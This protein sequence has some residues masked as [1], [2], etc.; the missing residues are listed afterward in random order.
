MLLFALLMVIPPWQHFSH[1]FLIFHDNLFVLPLENAF[2]KRFVRGGAIC[3]HSGILVHILTYLL[4]LR[5]VLQVVKGFHP[6][7]TNFFG[8]TVFLHFSFLTGDF[9]TFSHDQSSYF[10]LTATPPFNGQDFSDEGISI[11]KKPSSSS[12]S[13]SDDT[14]NHA[15]PSHHEVYAPFPKPAGNTYVQIAAGSLW[16][17]RNV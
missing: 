14:K 10:L 6:D 13:H 11:E 9:R 15:F 3:G 4:L 1:H 5:G 12:L 2:L 8:G 17:K 7:V 16:R